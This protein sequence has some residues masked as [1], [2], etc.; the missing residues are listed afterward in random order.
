[1]NNEPNKPIEAQ[2]LTEKELEGVVGGGK[3]IDID[4]GA[5]NS[6]V[7]LMAGGQ[8]AI[9]TLAVNRLMKFARLG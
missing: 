4:L 9:N 3:S 6:C 2:E 7:S 1:M 5:N 8:S